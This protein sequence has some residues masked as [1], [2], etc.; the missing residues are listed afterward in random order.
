MKSFAA[1]PRSHALAAL[2][3][4]FHYHETELPFTLERIMP[5]GRAHL[6]VNLAE[7][8]FRTYDPAWPERTNRHS[9]A[10]LAGPHG[11]STIIDMRAQRWLVAVEFRH[12]SMPM[13]EAN[14]VVRLRMSGAATAPR[15]AKIV[16]ADAGVE[17]SRL[18]CP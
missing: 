16:D 6:M 10:V 7:D 18:R 1:R 5:N 13:T 3:K 9:G 2:V 4:S 17:V 14:Q 15:C 8:D 11:S 12:F